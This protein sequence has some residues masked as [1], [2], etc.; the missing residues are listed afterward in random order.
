LGAKNTHRQT[1]TS[2]KKGICGELFQP[3]EEDGIVFLSR[4]ITDEE[5]INGVAPS[6]VATQEKIRGTDFCG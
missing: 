3:N 6:V 2:P 1:Q 4:I 5:T